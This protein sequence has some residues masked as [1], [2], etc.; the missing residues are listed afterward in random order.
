MTKD[1]RNEISYYKFKEAGFRGTLIAPPRYGKTSYALN[2]ILRIYNKFKSNLPSCMIIVRNVAVK[3]QWEYEKNKLEIEQ[4][5]QL[6]VLISTISEAMN[7][8]HKDYYFVVFDEIHRFLTQEGKFL[9]GKSKFNYTYGLGLTG[10]APSDTD[11]LNFL[12]MNLPIFDTITRKE[13]IDNNWILPKVEINI[14]L[15]L[16]EGDKFEYMRLSKHIDDTL[17]K[18]KNVHKFLEIP[19]IKDAFSVIRACYSGI[20]VP[21]EYLALTQ[22]ITYFK[23]TV[24]VN[25]VSETMTYYSNLAPNTEEEKEWSVYTVADECKMFMEFIRLRNDILINNEIKK[26]TVIE[27]AKLFKE[28][29]I[30]F[31]ESIRFAEDLLEEIEEQKIDIKP[32]IYH[33]SIESRPLINPLTNTFYTYAGGAKKGQPKYFGK[34]G[35]LKDTI[36]GLKQG[37]Y[38]FLITVKALD[39]GINVPNLTIV[40]CT[41]GTMNPIPYIQRTERASTVFEK[42]TPLVFNLVFNDFY[43]MVDENPHLIKNR[44]LTKLKIRQISAKSSPLWSNVTDLKNIANEY[45]NI[46]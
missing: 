7:F 30:C 31:N 32:T 1:E 43:I 14:L 19:F 17:K 3:Q 10:T 36:E 25:I 41:A 45:Y 12:K 42:R 8:R 5:I 15:E 44:D 37:W 34:K 28:P 27:I 13:A 33:G 23:S 46:V 2:I 18:Y 22:D 16:S 26:E 40:I 38:N 4:D 6:N 20:R 29:T 11:A 35:I 24:V 9:I 39:E 21:N